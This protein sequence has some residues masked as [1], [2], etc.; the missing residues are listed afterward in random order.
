MAILN[1]DNG[2]DEKLMIALSPSTTPEMLS[3]LAY[4]DD[5]EVRCAVAWNSQ[6]SVAALNLLAKDESKY[7]QFCVTRN[8]NA[9]KEILNSLSSVLKDFLSSD[10]PIFK[11]ESFPGLSALMAARQPQLFDVALNLWNEDKKQEA[12]NLLFELANEGNLEAI[13]ELCFIFIDQ[14]DYQ[15]VENILSAYLDQ[16]VDEDT[17]VYFRAKLL[18]A[19]STLDDDDLE[20]QDLTEVISIEDLTLV[21]TFIN[22][23]GCVFVGDPAELVAYTANEKE[24]NEV[25]TAANEGEQY[26][27]SFQGF[28]NMVGDYG[29][30][31]IGFEASVFA[32]TD[33]GKVYVLVD[34]ESHISLMLIAFTEDL[35]DQVDVDDLVNPDDLAVTVSSGQLMVGDPQFLGEWESSDSADLEINGVGHYSYSGAC[36]TTSANKYGLLG[37]GKSVVSSTGY[38]DGDY[39]IFYQV[40]DENGELVSEID[41]EIEG[42][43][44]PGQR[45]KL[46]VIDFMDQLRQD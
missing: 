19:Q 41:L 17:I 15:V 5:P 25:W 35:P 27:F 8:P 28:I 20:N 9:S 39:R 11:S 44:A 38:G 46:A 40:E 42:G 4:E 45:I 30:G 24:D 32:A 18:E 37:E 1:G 10:N 13:K 6:T 33:P 12:V 3:D 23:S 29:Y 22:K 43:L 36:A 34:K 31:N 2:I 14:K 16:D 7:V 21:G 26:S